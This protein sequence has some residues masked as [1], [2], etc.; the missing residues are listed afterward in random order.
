[1]KIGSLLFVLLA[2]LSLGSC[3]QDSP[4]PSAQQEARSFLSSTNTG[5]KVSLDLSAVSSVLDLIQEDRKQ[6]K[7][8]DFHYTPSSGSLRLMLDE[9]KDS[10]N[11]LLILRPVGG[12]QFTYALQRWQHLKAERKL[13]I[14]EVQVTLPQGLSYASHSW[15]AMLVLVPDDFTEAKL[16]QQGYKLPFSS[17]IATGAPLDLSQSRKLTMDIPFATSWTPLTKQQHAVSGD[18][19]TSHAFTFSPLGTVLT[20]KVTNSMHSPISLSGLKVVSNAIAPKASLDL[21]PAG[22]ARTEASSWGARF[23]DFGEVYADHTFTYD[24]PLTNLSSGQTATTGLVVWYPTTGAVTRTSF[25][26]NDGTP[27]TNLNGYI[28]FPD[29]F[30]S[31]DLEAAARYATTHVYALG[32]T[33]G[34]LAITKPNL[35]LV[36]IMGTDKELLSGHSYVLPN[37]LYEQPNLQLGYYAKTPLAIVSDPAT[38]NSVFA[39]AEEQGLSN[40]NVPLLSI[41]HHLANYVDTSDPASPTQRP[42]Q[43]GG[44][45]YLLPDADFMRASGL[46]S[47]NVLFHT[48]YRFGIIDASGRPSVADGRGVYTPRSI[49]AISNGQMGSSEP[50]AIITYS[51]L[52][53]HAGTCLMYRSADLAGVKG[54]PV[55]SPNQTV[56]RIQAHFDPSRGTPY[57]SSIDIRAVY[58]GKYYVGD[59]KPFVSADLWNG[60]SPEAQAFRSHSVTRRFF[61]GGQYRY[62]EVDGQLVGPLSD[63]YAQGQLAA[64]WTIDGSQFTPQG[65]SYMARPIVG[66]WGLYA[67]DGREYNSIWG[68]W[69]FRIAHPYSTTY[70]GD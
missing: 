18:E 34:G 38:G 28:R 53:A 10:Y 44:V 54:Q 19:L 13:Y 49:P 68:S 26:Y 48:D 59:L 55:R 31:Q 67:D 17:A 11:V 58:L 35:A 50:M 27:A 57:V 63:R 60:S 62:N 42:I 43:I 32:A 40:D 25:D 37:E 23:T 52:S 6:A 8:L 56:Y 7:S 22:L 36:P 61:V 4:R 47:T 66:A 65:N 29:N 24:L 51:D 3:Q 20:Y 2:I 16:Q 45:N 46:L 15:E 33:Q 41:Q 14:H 64:Y 69:S 5:E 12:N 1:M 70:Q 9:Q 39:L 30:H 21:T